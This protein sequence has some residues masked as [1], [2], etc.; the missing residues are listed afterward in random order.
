MTVAQQ[1]SCGSCMG[2]QLLVISF[3]VTRGAQGGKLNPVTSVNSCFPTPYS[4]TL[5]HNITI[6]TRD[7]EIYR[8]LLFFFLVV[9]HI[10]N[11]ISLLNCLAEKLISHLR[12]SSFISWS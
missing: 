5:R 11:Q 10:P 6:Y 3:T 4:V 9:S 1:V 8:G 2:R 12:V 7:T